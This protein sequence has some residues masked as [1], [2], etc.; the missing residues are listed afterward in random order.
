M[1]VNFTQTRRQWSSSG[2]VEEITVGSLIR[3]LDH[4]ATW[5]PQRARA[6]EHDNDAVMIEGLQD[7]LARG[8]NAAKVAAQIM[9]TIL[10]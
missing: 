6:S 4:E 7:V 3:F 10:L 2:F 1:K 5:S 9:F 8:K